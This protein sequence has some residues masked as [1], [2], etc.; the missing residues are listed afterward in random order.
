MQEDPLSCA[1][2]KSREAAERKGPAA[3]LHA[4]LM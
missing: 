2:E 3:A 1:T 4:P